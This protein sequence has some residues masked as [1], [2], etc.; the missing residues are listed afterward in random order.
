M[1]K[2]SIIIWNI[3]NKIESKKLDYL[4]CYKTNT[5]VN[6]IDIIN[7]WKQFILRE[8]LQLFNSQ[9]ELDNS[10]LKIGLCDFQLSLILEIIFLKQ[11]INYKEDILIF[12]IRNSNK[13][14]VLLKSFAPILEL[15]KIQLPY[16]NYFIE[17]D[18]LNI[19]FDKFFIDNEN[20]LIISFK[21]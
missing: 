1:D 20:L 18:Y 9:I 17:F 2:L 3:I 21:V 6:Y 5:D 16:W 12:Y 19:Y 4:K 15:N 10:S 14:L 7:I 8:D 13:L 11:I